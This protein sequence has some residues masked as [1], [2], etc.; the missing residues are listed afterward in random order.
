MYDRFTVM[1]IMTRT[2]QWQRKTFYGKWE[3][4]IIRIIDQE[5]MINCF[6]HTFCIVTLRNQRAWLSWSITMFN[7]C[8][9]TKSFIMSFDVIDNNSPLTFSVKSSEGTDVVNV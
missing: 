6:L 5:A 4:V 1:S 8:S 9:L 7:S 3:V 2:R